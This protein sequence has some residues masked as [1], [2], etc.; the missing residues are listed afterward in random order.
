M[1]NGTGPF[2]GKAVLITGAGTG[3]GAATARRMGRMGADVVLVGRR[4][5]P[6]KAVADQIGGHA[7]AADAA[8]P[9]GAAAAV[10]EAQRLFG[11][12]DIVVSNA[13]GHGF[14]A[15]AEVSDADWDAARRANLDTSVMILRAALPALIESQGAICLTASLASR[16]A[17]P[18]GFGYTAMKHAQ[19]GVM[20][21]I[22][23]D[24]GPKGVRCNAVCPGW[25]TTELAD[26]EMDELMQRRG[27]ASREEAYAL[28]TR[29]VPLR[30]PASPDDVA[31][32]IAFLCS[33]D[34]AA[35]TGTTLTVD[36]GTSVVGSGSIGFE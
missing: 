19:I 24:Y 13:G 25:V 18:E 17:A 8:D 9:D 23:R 4:M 3:I 1:D 26:A 32:A 34:A 7:F 16:F 6:L 5:D 10:A 36:G 28:L 35:I 33:P 12:L 15:L 21:S 11:R 31:A 22:A 2:A 29:N 14:A 27:L 30:C 20:R